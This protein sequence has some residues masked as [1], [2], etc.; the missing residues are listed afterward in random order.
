MPRTYTPNLGQ[1]IAQAVTRRVR[2]VKS[3]PE[4]LAKQRRTVGPDFDHAWRW[5]DQVVKGRRQD[6]IA[7]AVAEGIAHHDRAKQAV[8]RADAWLRQREQERIIA[9]YHERARLA[10]VRAQQIMTATALDAERAHAVSVAKAADLAARIERVETNWARAMDQI[11]H[12]KA[13]KA[14]WHAAYAEPERGEWA[15]LALETTDA[16]LSHAY[17]NLALALGAEDE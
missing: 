10:K 14:D 13:R 17:R 11:E 1:S 3:R 9:Q 4:P 5:V 8:A 2:I 15:E 7:E 6:V 16:A 12:D